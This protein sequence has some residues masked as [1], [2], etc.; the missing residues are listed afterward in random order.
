MRINRTNKNNFFRRGALFACG[1]ALLFSC[2]Q[3][4][5]PNSSAE[6]NQEPVAPK[7]A[8]AQIKSILSTGMGLEFETL[9]FKIPGN[10][11]RGEN[12]FDLS[13]STGQFQ[14]ATPSLHCL[15]FGLDAPID[16][17]GVEREFSLTLANDE[18]YFSLS[19]DRDDNASYDA[20]FMTSLQSYDEGG[21][22]DTTKGISYFEYGDLDYVLAEM[23]SLLGIDEINLGS[24]EFG[25]L[26]VDFDAIIDSMDAIEE[27]DSTRFVWELPLGKH[28][29]RL[30]LRH[31]QNG[32]LNGFEFPLKE[33]MT[34]GYSSITDSFELR[35]VATI[36][37]LETP[38]WSPRYEKSSYTPIVDSMDLFRQITQFIKRKSFGIDAHFDLFHGEDEIIGDDDHFAQDA[39][40]ENAYLNLFA[41]ADFSSSFF[42]GLHA[43]A[44]LGQTGG[45]EKY[46][47]VHSEDR[48]DEGQNIFLNV[49]NILK[50]ETSTTV[51]DALISSLKDALGDES[52]QNESITKLLSSLLATANGVFEAIK[53]VQNSDFY[54]N[55]DKKH[56][57]DVLSTIVDLEVSTNKIK[58]SVDLSGASLLGVATVT[59]NGT[60]DAMNLGRI[61]LDHVG[62]RST[63]DSHT[64][65]TINGYVDITPYSLPA[66]SGE[67]YTELTRLPHWTEEISAIAE[68]DQLSASI[69]GYALKRGTTAR[70]HSS[71]RSSICYNRGEQGVVFSGS[72]AFDLKERLGAGDIRFT[73]LKENYVNDHNLLLDLTGEAKEGETDEMDMAGSGYQNAMF[74]EYNSK[75]TSATSGS[76]AYNYEKRSEPNSNHPSLKGRFSVHSLNGILDVITE[77]G[78]ST[79]ARFARLTNLVGSLTAETLLTRALAG[80]YFELLSSKII[81]S[82]DFKPT[83]TTLI[84]APGLI[85]Q[86][87]GLTLTLGYDANGKP[88]TIEVSMSLEG[89]NTTDVYVKITLGETHFDSFPYR[90]ASHDFGN[91]KNF[92]S[93]KTLLQFAADTITLGVT[94][95]SS[96]TTYHLSGKVD[97]K[98]V[99]KTYTI[100]VDVFI[101]L[102]GSH[103]KIIG[104]IEAP[105]I[106]PVVTVINDNTFTE[107]YYESDGGDSAGELYMRR[108]VY[109][110]PL[111]GSGT[112]STSSRRVRG[113]D[114]GANLLDW[115][116]GYILN[117]GSTITNLVNS[118]SSSGQALH[119][120]DLILDWTSNDSVV[121][122]S[123][124]ITIGMEAITHISLFKDLELTI[125]GKTATYGGT[126]SKRALYSISGGLALEI[127]GLDAVTANLNFTVANIS[128]SGA[129]SDAWSSSSHKM[130]H[131]TLTSKTTG[132]LI[133][134][135]TYGV[136]KDQYVP[137]T[138]FSGSFGMSSSNSVYRNGSYYVK[139]NQLA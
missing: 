87:T 90:F 117:M 49:N 56:F 29:Y 1:G 55:I 42:G 5:V 103:I 138:A 136:Q 54:E 108:V 63:N 137:N 57:E 118:D 84:V 60:S 89:E 39:I 128:S 59:L 48:Q 14:M 30:G 10:P 44:R 24:T 91:F 11:S 40:S 83:S 9:E 75:N 7:P 130:K 115:L 19:A 25:A 64:T 33:G 37:T 20:K 96:V 100:S 121:N 76:A 3:E 125:Q 17:N 134:T 97:L 124:T 102:N 101:Y 73:E 34:Q 114:F 123:W 41:A 16:Y 47:L 52:I 116:L 104:C 92:S 21:V 135:T 110:N 15:R 74:F 6:S 82:V 31:D 122:P 98:V 70:V 66:F 72:L 109:S 85:Q 12:H 139:P 71:T 129:Y 26:T 61:E 32:V 38:D 68:Y 93:I 22:D 107:I 86:S 127:I 81:S 36:T 35:L 8:K 113:E 77:L 53:A 23:L 120:E 18:L 131:Y 133:K 95:T 106:K 112:G 132:W 46:L 62:L 79:D 88:K 67:G 105:E 28:T 51:A 45:Q 2:S 4:P 65:F 111:I 58:L 99:L 94:D 80:E 126:Y 119:G 50:V 69:E 13:S 43:E 78:S 27:Y